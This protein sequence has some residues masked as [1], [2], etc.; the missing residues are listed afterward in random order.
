MKKVLL[1]MAAACS[2][3]FMMF[4]MTACTAR[5]RT[6]LN[7]APR[8]MDTTHSSARSSTHNYNHSSPGNY[9]HTNPGANNRNNPGTFGG[10]TNH[11]P[12]N[13]SS[14]LPGNRGM[15]PTT[16]GRGTNLLTNEF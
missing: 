15:N 9:N 1:C 8:G 4:A 7:R 16:G 2:V 11:S 13:P 6:D 5:N 3:I 10:T 12:T 14:V